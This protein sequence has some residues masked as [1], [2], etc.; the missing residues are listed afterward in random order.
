[1][2]RTIILTALLAT[3]ILGCSDK[4]E[5]LY[6]TAQFEERQ[7]NVQHAKDLYREITTKYPNSSYAKDAHGRLTI[8]NQ[9]KPKQE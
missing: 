7:Q 3:S 1:M 6:M 9:D 5:E 4:A 2:K 8:L